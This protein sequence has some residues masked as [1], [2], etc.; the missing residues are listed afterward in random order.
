MNLNLTSVFNVNSTNI[1]SVIFQ[2][3]SPLADKLKANTDLLTGLESGVLLVNFMS[4]VNGIVNHKSSGY[5]HKEIRLVL[6][7]SSLGK[8]R[9]N[10]QVL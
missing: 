1:V 8:W 6:E 7:G 4:E 3:A 10:L 9:I 2:N 5:L